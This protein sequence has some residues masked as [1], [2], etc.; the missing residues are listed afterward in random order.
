MTTDRT[1]IEGLADLIC[2]LDRR[3]FAV[4]DTQLFA[5]DRRR[6][7]LVLVEKGALDRRP[8]LEYVPAG[9]D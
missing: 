4:V 8:P 9:D 7:S 6:V 1:G 3:G 2:E 5:H